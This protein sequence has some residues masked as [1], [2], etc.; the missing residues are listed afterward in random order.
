MDGPSPVG[1]DKRE[2]T[3]AV[4]AQTCENMGHH[5][6]KGFMQLDQYSHTDILFGSIYGKTLDG[7]LKIFNIF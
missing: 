2:R 7:Y 4:M 3:V 5:I 1:N 6:F